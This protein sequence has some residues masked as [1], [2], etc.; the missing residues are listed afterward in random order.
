MSGGG[1]QGDLGRGTIYKVVHGGPEGFDEPEVRSR[2]SGRSRLGLLRAPFLSGADV[3]SE[4]NLGGAPTVDPGP[5]KR[6]ASRPA[7]AFG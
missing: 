2:S 6:A 4:A 5:P 7:P 3:G 1:A